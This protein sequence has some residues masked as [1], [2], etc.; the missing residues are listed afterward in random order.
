MDLIE[1][2]SEGFPTYSY[3]GINI[4]IVKVKVKVIHSLLAEGAVEVRIP[5][6]LGHS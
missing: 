6:Y 3:H 1:S 4:V 2:V 5:L